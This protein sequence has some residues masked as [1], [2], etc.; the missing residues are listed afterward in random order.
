MKPPPG[1]WNGEWAADARAAAGIALGFP[2][3]LVGVDTAAGSISGTR[4]LLW[5]GLGLV[6]FAVLWP[7]KVSAVPGLLTT[8][9][10]VRR[11]HVHTDR[12]AS[13]NW[14]DG[15]AQRLLLEDTDGNRAE[16]DPRVF[17]ANPPLWHLLDR[18]IRTSLSHGT[19]RD[20]QQALRRLSRTIDRE[21]SRTVFK[22]SGLG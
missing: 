22:V 1:A 17:A 11:H 3:L 21:A 6:L 2:L 19:M 4:A 8:R 10:L 13:V 9:G 16:V 7:A 15:I 18:D 5:T 20:G 12:L 14:H